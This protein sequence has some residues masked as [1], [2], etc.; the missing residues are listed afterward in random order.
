M[1]VM[2]FGFLGNIVDWLSTAD[3]ETFLQQE[4]ATLIWMTVVILLLIPLASALHGLL[5]RQTVMGNTPM[6]IRWL[7]HR[8]LLGQSYAFYQDE[9]AGRISTKL[10]QTSTAVRDT[11]M[12][13]LDVLVYV[14]IYFIGA[15]VLVASFDLWLLVPFLIWLTLYVL[16]LKQYCL[17]WRWHLSTLR[18]KIRL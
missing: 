11:A 7:G 2:L 9:F 12:K 16:L 3:R 10:L 6:I 17:K 18:I 4:S 8:Y 5:L 13:F 14:G 15:L 1:E